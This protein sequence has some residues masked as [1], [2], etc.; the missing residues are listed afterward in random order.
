M[1]DEVTERVGGANQS[2]NPQTSKG[3]YLLFQV[4]RLLSRESF[5]T[6]PHSKIYCYELEKR[7][8]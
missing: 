5:I 4:P 1:V 2:S 7:L 6:F 8:F 3:G